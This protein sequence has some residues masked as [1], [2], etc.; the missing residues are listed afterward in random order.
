MKNICALCFNSVDSIQIPRTI[1]NIELGLTSGFNCVLCGC[2][3]NHD[4]CELMLTPTMKPSKKLRQEIDAIPTLASVQPIK[5]TDTQETVLSSPIIR[6]GR[7]STER[8]DSRNKEISNPE[9]KI[10]ESPRQ[11]LVQRRNARK[12]SSEKSTNIS[13]NQANGIIVEKKR[14]KKSDANSRRYFQPFFAFC[15]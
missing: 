11:D 6:E 12:S 15:F 10:E 1:L 3:L 2:E 14:R 13:S 9:V 4:P 5:K 7:K 8:N